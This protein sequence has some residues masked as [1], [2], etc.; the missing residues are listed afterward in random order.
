MKST[1]F[2]SREVSRPARSPGLSSTGPEVTLKP[3]PSSLAMMLL[4]VVFPSPGG[5]CSSVWSSGSPRRRAALT[6]TCRLSTTLSCPLKSL[7]CNGRSAFSNSRSRLLYCWLRMS[8]FS[9]IIIRIQVQ[10]VVPK[11]S[12]AGNSGTMHP[13]SRVGSSDTTH[14]QRYDYFCNAS[15]FTP[16]K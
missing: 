15:F 11:W 12:S 5:P 9:S 2:G 3:T 4:R 14:L 13:Y 6:N 16:G 10:G 1:S 8:K 7:N